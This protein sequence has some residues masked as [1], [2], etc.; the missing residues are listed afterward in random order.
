MGDIKDVPSLITKLQSD[1]NQ[2]TKLISQFI[3]AE[4]DPATKQLMTDPESTSP[5]RQSALVQA[6]NKILRGDSIYEPTRFAGVTLRP[7]TQSLITQSPTGERLIRLNRLLL[8]DAYP[9]EIARN[10]FN[11]AMGVALDAA[12][13]N[14]FAAMIKA[15][16]YEGAAP[17][18][19]DATAPTKLAELFS[20]ISQTP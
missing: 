10:P 9:L 15:K 17:D 3:W 1:S 19:W 14:L 20:T 7:E 6:L 2:S 11:D 12:F 13:S 16:E 5:Q 8:E 18:F 4:V